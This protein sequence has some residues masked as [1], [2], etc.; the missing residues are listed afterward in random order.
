M[1]DA[2]QKKIEKVANEYN[3]YFNI[4]G[5]PHTNSAR[6]DARPSIEY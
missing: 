1:G 6:S 3:L 5:N 4:R 2:E